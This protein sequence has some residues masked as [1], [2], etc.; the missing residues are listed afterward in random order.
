M[1]AP[2]ILFPSPDGFDEMTEANEVAKKF[3]TIIAGKTSELEIL[4][5]SSPH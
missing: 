2:H 1:A 3:S 4:K 5:C